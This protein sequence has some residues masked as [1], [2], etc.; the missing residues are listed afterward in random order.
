MKK[1]LFISALIFP[2]LFS[3]C[4]KESTTLAPTDEAKTFTRSRNDTTSRKNARSSAVGLGKFNFIAK[5]ISWGGGWLNIIAGRPVE[6]NFPV[7]WYN[8]YT[9]DSDWSPV[10][11]QWIRLGNE[12]GAVI[13]T[14]PQGNPWIAKLD[15]RIFRWD[16]ANWIFV[17]GIRAQDIAISSN[18]VVYVTQSGS[19]NQAIYRYNPNDGSWILI[20]GM[21]G[22]R[23]TADDFDQPIVA[24]DNGGVF[25]RNFL[26]GNWYQLGQEKS[27]DVGCAKWDL[28]GNGRFSGLYHLGIGSQKNLYVWTHHSGGFWNRPRDTWGVRVD[29]DSEGF[30]YWLNSNGELYTN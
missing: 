15:G 20:E 2:V 6:A 24:Q 7:Y 13:D 16:G 8:K 25:V 21:T 27:R 12:T 9:Y 3:S 23:I 22:A 10:N 19:G 17:D 1:L 30:A 28:Y 5:D 26:N 4:S 11:G 14:D 29:A 18:G